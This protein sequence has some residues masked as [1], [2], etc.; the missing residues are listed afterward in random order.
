MSA[1]RFDGTW[2]FAIGGAVA[3]GVVY[4]ATQ[5]NSINP[6]TPVIPPTPLANI[7]TDATGGTALANPV[8]VDG[9]GNFFFY[10]ATGTYTLVYFDPF[11]RAPS[12]VFP[13]QQVVSPGGGSVTSVALTMP[14]EFTVAGSPIVAAGTLA[15]TKANENANRGFMGPASGGAA[16]PTFRALVTADLPAG[17]GTVTSVAMTV[18]P[19]AP[20]SASVG[21]TPITAAGT[22]ALTLG[23]ANQ[24]ANTVIAGPTSGA[25]AAP[26]ARALIPA[27]LPGQTAVSFSATP[28]FNAASVDS[29]KITLTGNVTSSTITNPTAGQR[30]AFI[31][32][33]DGT[34][35]R[36]FA[37]PANGKGASVV[38]PDANL[39]TV[40]EFVYD[41][42]A[43][44]WC[45]LSPGISML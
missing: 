45:A 41:G 11:N 14:A 32:T 13:D 27:D 42:V 2:N 34:G 16:A 43:A 9:N 22:L 3:G 23:L 15:V 29:F 38:A 5:P 24:G 35:G 28:V 10:A 19:T 7:F 12:Q 25:A 40:Q 20:V 37:W 4:V 39:T 30:V 17:T 8:T 26:T 44:V 21:G 18:T 1:F 33:Q 6:T 31:I 36:T